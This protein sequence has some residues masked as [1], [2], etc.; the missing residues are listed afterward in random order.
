MSG[1]IY[2]GHVQCLILNTP[3][4]VPTVPSP[5]TLTPVE[6]GWVDATDILIGS[7]ALNK[8]DRILYSRD[9]SGVF[10]VSSSEH[11]RGVYTSLIAL[12]L[13]IPNGNNGDYAIVDTGGG[14]NAKQY[15]WDAQ[16][17]WVLGSGT[18]G[19]ESFNGRTGPV[20]P[21]AGDYPPAFIGAQPVDADLT[22]LAN[23][24]WQDGDFAY[25]EGGTFVRKTTA[26]ILEILKVNRLLSIPW[27]NATVT[28]TLS[29]TVIG[30]AILIPANTLGVNDS[31]RMWGK[32]S[33]SNANARMFRAYINTVPN[34]T[35]SPI[36]ILFHSFSNALLTPFVRNYI[37]RGV[38]NSTRVHNISSPGTVSDEA[39]TSVGTQTLA[40][41]WTVDQYIIRT[42]QVTISTADAITL[43]NH[44]IQ[45][46][47][48]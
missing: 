38:N 10:I 21:V 13:A 29:E 4:Q 6:S 7:L 31:I 47:K 5:P 19:V 36:N 27:V 1:I 42:L 25:R 8:V 35:G 3:G 24:A 40:I 14:S 17:G 39:N 15:I 45:L 9:S 22:A 41:D 26:Q 46:L 44:F 48:A 32:V 33:P 43:E 30:S 23:I 34:L 11:F 18:G 2:N 12:Q 16:D 20:F 37:N 28:G